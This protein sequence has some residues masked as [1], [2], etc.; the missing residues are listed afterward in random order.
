MPNVKN[1]AKSPVQQIIR[2]LASLGIPLRAAA[3]R[4]LSTNESKL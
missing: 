3:D 2:K 4:F 1:H